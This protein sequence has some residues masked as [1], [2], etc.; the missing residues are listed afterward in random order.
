MKLKSLAPILVAVLAFTVAMP[1]FAQKVQDCHR[2]KN[3]DFHLITIDIKALPAHVAHGDGQPGDPVPDLSGFIFGPNCTPTVAPPPE[4][5]IGC[6]TLAL[7][8]SR[9]EDM[10]YAGPIDVLG[11]LTIFFDSSDGTCS[12]NPRQDL[13][14]GIIAAGNATDAQNKCDALTASAGSGALVF[15]LGPFFTPS[16]PGFWICL[17][18]V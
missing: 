9:P 17:G 6:Y 15:D 18:P 3:G 7:P 13:Q 4:L 5:A 1:A 16:A 14:D 12:G 2:S 11:N 8:G 10:F